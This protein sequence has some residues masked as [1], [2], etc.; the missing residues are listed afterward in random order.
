MLLRCTGSDAVESGAPSCR[1]TAALRVLAADHRRAGQADNPENPGLGIR[2]TTGPER[3]D[4]PE[5]ARP[6]GMLA[7]WEFAEL[8]RRALSSRSMAKEGLRPRNWRRTL[9]LL[10]LRLDRKYTPCPSGPP[11]L[12]PASAGVSLLAQIGRSATRLMACSGLAAAPT[13]RQPVAPVAMTRALGQ[14][15]H[16]PVC[17]IWRRHRAIGRGRAAAP[18]RPHRDALPPY[19]HSFPNES[20]PAREG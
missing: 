4:L 10:G 2:E 14:P 12:I 3:I 16:P 8:P 6:P 17:G 18:N 11:N 7:R 20:N 5:L 9:R 13:T 1:N 19:R 15:N